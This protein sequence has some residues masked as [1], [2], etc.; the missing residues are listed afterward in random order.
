MNFPLP[1]IPLTILAGVDMIIPATAG[2]PGVTVMPP[3]PAATTSASEHEEEEQ[4]PQDQP[5]Q[6][7]SHQ[8]IHPLPHRLSAFFPDGIGCISHAGSLIVLIL[9]QYQKF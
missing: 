1:S 6:P 3:M 5:D 8:R 2:T 7:S 4:S 9:Q